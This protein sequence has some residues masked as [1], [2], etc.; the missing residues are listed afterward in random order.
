MK[1]IAIDLD[2]TLLNC[3]NEI[4]KKNIE[5]IRYAQGLGIEVVIAT[6]R[7]YFD[8]KTIC[9]KANI[10]TYIIGNNGATMNDKRENN[11]WEICMDKDEVKSI[12][13]WLE[14][15]GFYYEVSTNTKIYTPSNG[16]EI[17]NAEL[18]HWIHQNPHGAS[19]KLYLALEKQFSQSGFVF[20]RDS[21]EII[22]QNENFLNVLAFSFN[23]NKR[24]MGYEY[25]SKIM[26]LSVFSSAD[27]NFELTNEAASKGNGLEKLSQLLN[28]S[29]E[30]T[31]AIG[32]NYNDVSMFKKAGYSVAM[33]NAKKDIKDICRFT[34][35]TNDE[36]GVAY[37]IYKLLDEYNLS[38][39]DN[40][41][42]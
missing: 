12:I 23:E 4:S 21:A 18:S 28:I 37:I 31:I 35:K 24:S 14:D 3:K 19:E 36:H 17:L 10:S 29:L 2:G 7:S 42:A 27:H 9:N 25:F 11:L 13:Q 16:R 8:A 38:L 26:P 5:A 30:E 40:L 22:K 15:E 41:L 39:R 34:T 32:D 1:L 20:V 33:G 6:G